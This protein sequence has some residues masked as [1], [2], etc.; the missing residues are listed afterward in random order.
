MAG[1]QH[2]HP[3]DETF[4]II[5]IPDGVRVNAEAY[6][7]RRYSDPIWGKGKCDWETRLPVQLTLSNEAIS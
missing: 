7:L 1:D 3:N 6:R 2:D 4:P 5:L